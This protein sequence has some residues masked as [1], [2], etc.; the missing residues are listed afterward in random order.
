LVRGYCGD[1]LFIQLSE[2]ELFFNNA[3][4]PSDSL[5]FSFS[6]QLPNEGAVSWSVTN[7]NDGILTNGCHSGYA[8]AFSNSG[9]ALTITSTSAFD[10]VVVYNLYSQNCWDRINGATITSTIDGSQSSA[11]FPLAAVAQYTFSLSSGSLIYSTDKP[12]TAAPTAE[13]S[14]AAPSTVVI[15]LPSGSSIICDNVM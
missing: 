6:S 5:T 9:P 12:S 8:D 14:N 13:P 7:C 4:L 11:L 2:V 10:K 15:A 3:Q 1:G